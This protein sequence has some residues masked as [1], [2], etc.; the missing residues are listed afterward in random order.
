MG[1]QFFAVVG[2]SRI[3]FD[4]MKSQS[5]ILLRVKKSKIFSSDK[6]PETEETH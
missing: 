3:L 2:K 5:V 4:K 6:E 1:L